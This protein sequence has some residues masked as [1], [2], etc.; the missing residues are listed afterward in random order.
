MVNPNGRVVIPGHTSAASALQTAIQ[1]KKRDFT[2]AY[3]ILGMASTIRDPTSQYLSNHNNKK[4]IMN[5]CVVLTESDVLMVP[6]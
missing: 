1:N 5:L 3:V 6:Q 2:S 4:K